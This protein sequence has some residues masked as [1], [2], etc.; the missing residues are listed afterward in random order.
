MQSVHPG[1]EDDKT[2]IGY[3]G[4]LPLGNFEYALYIR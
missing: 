4:L 2:E 3:I 1:L